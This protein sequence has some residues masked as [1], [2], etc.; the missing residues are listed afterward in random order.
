M[1]RPGFNICLGPDSVLLKEHIEAL[2][3][4]HAPGSAPESAAFW[5]KHVFWAD[6]P[7]EDRFWEK[8]TQQGLF[9]QP[10]AVIL[11]QAQN[12]LLEQNGD[13]KKISAA[14]GRGSEQIWP[15][16][17]FEVP[18]EK[19]K[20][21]IPP[22]VQKLQ[23][24]AFARNHGWYR[25]IP[26]LDSRSLKKF[27]SKEA[28]GLGLRLSDADLETLSSCMPPDA[29]A[30]KLEMAK[31][32]L[33]CPDRRLTEEALSMLEFARGMDI[34][35]F[36][37]GLQSGK[38]PG[39]VWGKFMQDQM[40]Y[41]DAGLFAFLGMLQREAR[42]LWGLLAGEQVALPSFL[43][44]SKTAL[45]KSLG[46]GKLARVWDFAL[47]ADKGVKTGEHNPKQAFEI[48]IANLFQL[49]RR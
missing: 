11:R 16:L 10:R 38:N 25:E 8:L 28:A 36:L 1:P 13:L 40:S 29:G 41:D 17:C 14:L 21:K 22:A 45:A 27:V 9:D 19:G 35:A 12:K 37:Q 44:Q 48:L 49:F 47:A 30:I 42:I 31:I 2:L 7:L 39:A 15:F 46:F 24:V 34:F 3:E 23:C 43:V 33:A 26:P 20:I 32:A 5:E 18:Y 4:A 6:E